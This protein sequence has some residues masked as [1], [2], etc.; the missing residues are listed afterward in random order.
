[1]P[2]FTPDSP[3]A[4]MTAAGLQQLAGGGPAGGGGGQ[5]EQP[6]APP[7]QPERPAQAMG[8]PM[9]M[10]PGGQNMAAR[11][12]AQQWLQ[13]QGF[14]VA[15]SLADYGLGGIKPAVASGLPGMT[16]NS[17]SQWQMALMGYDPS[18]G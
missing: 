18:Q 7:L 4:R 3:G 11:M 1:L 6:A 2:G 12:A 17:P 14:R 8:G 10:Q 9:M 15:P 5:G 16:L 13:A